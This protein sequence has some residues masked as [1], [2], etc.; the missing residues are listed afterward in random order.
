[1]TKRLGITSLGDPENYDLSLALRS[2]DLNLLELTN[3]YATFA[4]HGL[5]NDLPCY[6]E[7]KD[8][9]NRVIASYTPHPQEVLDPGVAFQLSSILSDNATRQEVFDNVLNISRP[10]AVKTG[11]T[12]NYRDSLT[13]G[14][15]PSVVVGVWVGNNDNTQMDQVAGAIG[16]AP[17]WKALVEEYSKNLPTEKFNPPDDINA[18][19]ICK[20]TGLKL[21]ETGSTA[22]AQEYF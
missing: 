19:A 9:Q 14:F 2:G 10:A 21:K 5:K 11:T 22:S 8:K 16:A 20:S 1:M 17:I 7:I 4:N 3:A 18:I 6:T 13:M 12:E 15:T